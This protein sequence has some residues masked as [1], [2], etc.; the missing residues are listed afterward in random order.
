METPSDRCG[1]ALLLGYAM[2]RPRILSA[3]ITLMLIGPSGMMTP[4]ETETLVGLFSLG[5]AVLGVGGTLLGGW[6]QQRH[7]VQV[8]RE[9]R[10]EAR[11]SEMESRGRGAAEKALIE[12]HALRRH[13]LAWKVGMSDDER[14]QWVGAAHAMVDEAELNVDLVPRADTLRVRLRDALNVVRHSFFEDCYEADHEAYKSEFDTSHCIGL[15]AAYMRGDDALPEPT[16][17]EERE[18]IQRDMRAEAGT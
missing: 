9:E 12:L 10:A 6:F 8:A 5:G 14:N 15:L 7:Q 11:S 3:E 2:S 13:A 18:A 4:V 1:L 17:R 16:A